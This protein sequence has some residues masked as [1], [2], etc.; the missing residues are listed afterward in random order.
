MSK[1]LKQGGRERGRKKG[2][3]EEGESKPPGVG[4]GSHYTEGLFKRGGNRMRHDE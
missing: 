2:R 1:D 4:K 3:K